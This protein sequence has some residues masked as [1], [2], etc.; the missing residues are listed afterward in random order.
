MRK[1]VGTIMS[2]GPWDNLSVDIVGPR[3]TD[4]GMEYII[5]FV[6]C[7]SKYAILIPSKNHTTATV[8]NALLTHVIPYFG[9]PPQLCRIEAGNL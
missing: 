3:P 4:R 9:V 7:Y 5:T 6:D 8:C 2:L 1:T